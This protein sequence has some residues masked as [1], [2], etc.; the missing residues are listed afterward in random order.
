MTA[1]ADRP[2]TPPPGNAAPSGLVRFDGGVRLAAVAALWLG[3]LLV[4]YW[5]TAGGG[6][7][8]LTGWETGLTSTGRLCG[9]TASVLLLAQVLM[10]T[11]LPLLEHAFGQDRLARHHRIVGFTSFN[12][13]LAHIVLITWGYATGELGAVPAT[14]WQLVTTYPGVLLALAGTACLVLAVV[15]SVKAARRRTRYESWHLLHLYAYLGVGLALPHQ[16]WSGQEFLTS[17][18]A[19]V[20]WWTAWALTVGATLVWRIG[21]PLWRNL[22]HRLRVTSVVAEDDG[23]YSVYLAGRHL[24]RLPVRAGQFFQWRFL[25]RK[26]WTRAHPY[27]LSAA[28][29]GH[30]LRITAKALGDDSA[31]IATL[32]AGTPVLI[33]GPY[34]RLSDR[35]R[36]HRK[37]ALIGAGVGITPLRALAE[38]LDGRPGEV[39]VLQRYAER[40]LFRQELEVLARERGLRLLWLPGHRRGADS[41]LGEGPGWADDL[42]A[43]R[44]WVP[45]IAER[46][47]YVCGP[48]PWTA[49][50]CRC[51]EAAGVPAERLHIENFAW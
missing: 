40:P 50:V 6:L 25:H 16:L 37:V 44:Y 17:T 51:V 31:R 23:V 2:G 22:R 30:S 11:R 35:A 5:W 9:L 3:L 28:P 24:D 38:Q 13:M 20:F 41:W 7:Q 45:D 15:T 36:A 46:D 10:M 14:F 18:A 1:I 33:E 49:M 29:D 8:D 21:V 12:L 26:G 32:R 4:T 47:V 42:T 27:S 43:L 39:V 34:G 48:E 19:T